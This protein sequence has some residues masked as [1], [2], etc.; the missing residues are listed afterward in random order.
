MQTYKTNSEKI[1]ILANYREAILIYKN[2]PNIHNG[3]LTNALRGFGLVLEKRR[4]IEEAIVVWKET[5]ELY[6]SI[7]LQEG[8]EEANQKIK[9][10][11]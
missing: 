10:L 1:L 3:D 5:K 11:S 2:N 7:Y 9:S 6:R 4:E 8:V